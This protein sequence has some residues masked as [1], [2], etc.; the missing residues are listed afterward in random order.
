MNPI[1]REEPVL[2]ALSEAVRDRSALQWYAIRQSTDLRTWST[3]FQGYQDAQTTLSG[4]F[5]TAA[6][7]KIAF[8]GFIQAF[9]IKVPVYYRSIRLVPALRDG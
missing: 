3:L 8:P 6:S 4:T 7:P 9:T 5:L 1:G 2:D